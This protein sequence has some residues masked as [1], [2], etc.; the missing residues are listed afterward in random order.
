MKRNVLFIFILI[1]PLLWSCSEVIDWHDPTDSVPPGTVSNVRV[2]NFNGGA[3]ILYT[4]P[5]TMICYR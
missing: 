4:R 2:T 5:P 3:T 1:M